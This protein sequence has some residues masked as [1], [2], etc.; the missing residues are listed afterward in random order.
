MTLKVAPRA[1]STSAAITS[2]STIATSPISA[3][4]QSKN[5]KPSSAIASTSPTS[6]ARPTSW[7]ADSM[8]LAGRK[9]V[10]SVWMPPS[11]GRSAASASSTPRVTSRVLAP[12]SL[13]ITSSRL[14]PSE[15]RASPISGWWSE[16]TLAT[17]PSRS[18]P[19]VS[20]TVT[21]ARSRGV[22]IG[23][24]CWMP[25]RWL[26]LS[27]NPPVPGVEASTKL[28]GD[29]H[30]ALPVVVSTWSSETPRFRSRSGSTWTWSCWSRSP[31]MATLA[32]PGTPIRRGRIF[33]RASTDIWIS[34]RSL[35]VRPIIMTRLVE[36]VGWS[37]TGG[38]E[39]CGMPTAAW[40]I[41]SATS[42]RARWRLVPGSKTRSIEDSPGIDSEWIVFS[43]AT[44]LSRSCSIGTVIICSTSLAD[45][46]SASVWMRTCGGENS[47]RTS[48]GA[49][50]S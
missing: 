5:T 35:E 33:H 26:G 1:C 25:S 6:S 44:P 31:Q 34:D 38:L 30:S 10:E 50:P 46:P 29:T 32:T 24:S 4:R 7:M 39:T 17:S 21:C 16:T 49:R 47:G 11:P 28:S 15:T 36:E 37:I 2:D 23:R 27:T 22:L 42:W 45:R 13:E 3:L 20:S 41:R 14:G 48:T 40:V 8:K 18:L 19:L 12:G 9:M 43:Q